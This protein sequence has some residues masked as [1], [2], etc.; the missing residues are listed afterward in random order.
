MCEF[1]AVRRD[2]Y[3]EIIKFAVVFNMRIVTINK[4]TQHSNVLIL[5]RIRKRCTLNLTTY[6]KGL[7]ASTD[8]SY[9]NLKKKRYN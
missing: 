2:K 5:I 7:L 9:N 4:T 8:F 3:V 1:L 6:K